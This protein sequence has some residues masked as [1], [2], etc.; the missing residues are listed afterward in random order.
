MERRRLAV[1]LSHLSAKTNQPR[2]WGDCGRMQR[3]PLQRE[4]CGGKEGDANETDE[5]GVCC[6]ENVTGNSN[7]VVKTEE[8]S[9]EQGVGCNGRVYDAKEQCSEMSK[10]VVRSHMTR[11]MEIVKEDEENCVFCDVVRGRA[12]ALKL[13]EDETCLCILDINPLSHGHSLIIPK[14]HFS[15]LEVTP[16]AVAAAMCAIVPVLGNAIMKATCADSF[17]LLV[18]SGASAGQEIFHT[19]FHIIPR[20][21]HDK[22]WRS[23][24]EETPELFVRFQFPAEDL[25]VMIPA[26]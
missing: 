23:E 26:C 14:I 8:F 1:I 10:G 17:N 18:N 2:S 7:S 20:S 13:Y 22:L 4:G 24:V 5:F 9:V 21:R 11:S 12:P 6:R 15:S 3:M 16:S 19:H 25:S